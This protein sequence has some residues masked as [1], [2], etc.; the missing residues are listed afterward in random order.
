M[1]RIYISIILVALILGCSK[2]PKPEITD[3]PKDTPVVQSDPKPVRVHTF[4]LP[5]ISPLY[6]GVNVDTLTAKQKAQVARLARSLK[7]FPKAT[8]RIDGYA[9]TTG[10]ASYN[11]KL[12]ERRAIS[13]FKLLVF[14][15][16]DVRTFAQGRGELPGTL[17]ESRK[18]TI[19]I[20]P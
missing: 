20:N 8:V 14:E 5:S 19:T 11:L 7:R 10:R 3:W 2:K 12:S 15:N 4:S 9:D 16:I 1:T 6:F 13:V 18:V 17:A